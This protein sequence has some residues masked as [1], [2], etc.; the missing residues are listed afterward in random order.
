MKPELT[1]QFLA[2]GQPIKVPKG[3]Q[4]LQADSPV[5]QLYY[6]KE[7]L[8][9]AYYLKDGKE[10]TDWFGTPDTYITSLQGYHANGTS[11]QFIDVLTP[12]EVVVLEKANVEKALLTNRA[13]EIYYRDIITQHLLRLQERITALQFFTAAQRYELLLTK[14][15]WVVKHASRTH[16]ASYLGISLETLSRISDT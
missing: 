2:L 11:S 8:V 12:T 14:N 13:L 1:E 16:I 4:L 5:H 10:V 7:G 9:R 6:I 3:H 15:P